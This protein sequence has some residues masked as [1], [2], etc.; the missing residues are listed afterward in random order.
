MAY[1]ELTPRRYRG[2]TAK[3]MAKM[4]ANGSV[5][6]VHLAEH[7]LAQAEAAEPK[8]NA[9]VRFLEDDA[10]RAAEATEAEAKAGRLRGALHGVPIAVKDNF[11]LRGYPVTRGSRTDA[12]NPATENA[13]MIERVLAAGAVIIGKTTMPEF[14]WKGTGIS[15]CLLYTS[16]S[17]RDVEEPRMPS[18][19]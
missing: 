12:G 19:A 8:L 14:G 16:P 11:Y 5:S 18:S 1:Q 15:P 3:R 13:P 6:P 4:V 9:Y 10:R 17:P 2:L 7:A